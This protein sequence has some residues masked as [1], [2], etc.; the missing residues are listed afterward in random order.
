MDDAPE[1]GMTP[2][3]RTLGAREMG[4]SIAASPH[5][6]VLSR[7]LRSASSRPASLAIGSPQND[8]SRRTPEQPG[9]G[10]VGP[11]SG[12]GRTWKALHHLFLRP[13]KQSLSKRWTAFPVPDRVRINSWESL[14][15]VI[16]LS[17]DFL[18][19]PIRSL[20]ASLATT[21]DVPA[22][23]RLCRPMI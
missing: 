21:L 5:Y 13:P 7:L 17:V 20:L 2:K 10:L 12:A 14:R 1:R 15:S 19:G 11:L 3:R 8:A 16:R 6:P 23:R 4:A 9:D 18:A 22:V